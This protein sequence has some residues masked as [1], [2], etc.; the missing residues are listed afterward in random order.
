[1]LRALQR[2]TAIAYVAVAVAL[3]SGIPATGASADAARERVGLELRALD[4]HGRSPGQLDQRPAAVT[5]RLPVAR[6]L[7]RARPLRRPAVSRVR[8]R[9]FRASDQPHSSTSTK[10]AT[11][12]M[13][14]L[15]EHGPVIRFRDGVFHTLPVADGTDRTVSGCCTRHTTGRSGSPVSG[16]GRVEGDQVVRYLPDEFG[17]RVNAIHVTRDGALW[18]ATS[19]A[20]Q[21]SPCR[22]PTGR[23]RL[24]ASVPQPGLQRTS[25]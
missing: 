10:P 16:I 6:H 20:T 15:A 18:V 22:S 3:A 21:V 4:G 17:R 8:Q 1:M 25:S 23:P 11:A 2:A 14:L 7:R 5:R 24:R 12:R 13:W 9:Q 19:T